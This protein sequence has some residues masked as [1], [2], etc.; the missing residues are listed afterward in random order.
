MKKRLS[1]SV[2]LELATDIERE[3]GHL[4]QLAAEL[5]RVQEEILRQPN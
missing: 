3:L 4:H 5:Q 2:L 1:T